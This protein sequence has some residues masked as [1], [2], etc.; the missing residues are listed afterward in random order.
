MSDVQSAESVD[1]VLHLLA[2]CVET[3]RAENS[4]EAY[5]PLIYSWETRD[6]AA[7]ADAGLFDDADALRRMIVAF[8]NRYFVAR[9]RFRAGEPTPKAW[10]L[11]F[12]A[13]RSSAGLVLQHLLL[14]F[15]A[16]V[17]VDL[18]AAAAETGLPFADYSRVDA[19]LG[20][21]VSKVQRCLN[22]TTMV[23]RIIDLFAGDFDE[24]LT[25]F[26]LKAARRHAFELAHR[27][28]GV[29]EATRATLIAEA[30]DWALRLGQRLLRPPLRDRLLLAAVQLSQRNA[31]PRD[32]LAV[33]E[34]P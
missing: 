24:M 6:I 30:D 20:V 18:A 14:A 22:R 15:N 32:L 10:G 9:R 21:G 27:L 4:A 17:N 3:A 25:I 31:S 13:A 8:A 16:H 7:A 1:E 23:L 28:R 34:R 2:R 33:L 11:A 5:F 19:I 29:P 26:S 12:R